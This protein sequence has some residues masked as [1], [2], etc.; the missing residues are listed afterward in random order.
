M[1]LWEQER[2]RW[3]RQHP[4]PRSEKELGEFRDLFGER[5]QRWLDMGYGSCVLRL[6]CAR[7]VM[8]G[9]LRHFDG[10]RYELREMTVAGNHVHVLLRMAGGI[11]LSEAQHSWK[12]FTAHKLLE[13]PEVRNQWNSG[14]S[15]WQSESFDHIVRDRNALERYALYIQRHT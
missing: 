9:A 13:T 10:K 2:R 11:D 6:A 8:E 12:S 5:L 1:E 3:F 7:D 14:R 4:E 15:L